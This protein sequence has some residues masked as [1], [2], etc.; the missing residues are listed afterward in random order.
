MANLLKYGMYDFNKI[1]IF[2]VMTLVGEW[3]L[4]QLILRKLE[5]VC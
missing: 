5:K 1:A 2:I 4:Y 3:E